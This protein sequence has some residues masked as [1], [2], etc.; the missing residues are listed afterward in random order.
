M[1][2]VIHKASRMP[3]RESYNGP[4]CLS[5][6]VA[7]GQVYADKRRALRDAAKLSAYGGMFKVSPR[8][9]SEPLPFDLTQPGD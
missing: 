3:A 7:G 1:S 4:T 5:A 6:D 2:Y 8:P 9:D